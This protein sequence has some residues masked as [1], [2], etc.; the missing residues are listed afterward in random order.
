[1][2][3]PPDL[4][5]I[6]SPTEDVVVRHGAT[7]PAIGGAAYISALAARWAG[8]TAGVVAR[9]PPV[10][11]RGCS[12]SFGPNGLHREGLQPHDGSLPGFRITY[13]DDDHATY[14][15]WNMGLE[16]Q[17]SAR[18]IPEHW[19][20]GWV[21][22][23]GVGASVKMQRQ[24]LNDLPRNR[25]RGLSIGTCKAMVQ[26]SP[27][28][29]RALLAASDIFFL[30]EEEW[31]L[32][33][34]N[35][36]PAGHTGT[37]VVTRGDRGVTVFRGTSVQEFQAKPV[38]VLDPTGAGDAFCGAF[39]GAL[40]QG[41][42][43][44]ATVAIRAA[45]IV[46]GGLGASPLAEW[47]GSQITSRAGHDPDAL[48][49]IAPTV[50]ANAQRSAFDFT[51][52]PHLPA[53][54]PLALPMLWISTLHQ[55]GFWTADASSGWHAPM[56]APIDGIQRKGSDFIWAAFARAAR[57]DPSS[58]SAARMAAEPDLFAE[59]CRDD[60]G[61]CPVPDLESHC[62]LHVAHGVH[63]MNHEPHGYAPILERV[64]NSPQPI[65]SLLRVVEHQPGYLGDPMA[66]KANLLAVIL[67][68]RPERWLD[69][70]DPSS[71]Q[72]IVDYHMMRLCMRTGL[73]R[74]EDPDLE[75]RLAQRSWVDALEE[76]EIRR[77]TGRA[78]L[79]LV[80]QTGLS[81]AAI[82]GLF[83]RLGRSVCLETSEP[84]CTACPIGGECPQHADLFQPVFRT[85]AY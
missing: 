12:R 37:I 68:A 47:V 39:L 60:T 50:E 59:I 32:L 35:G 84:E 72:P 36:L 8:A 77:A 15:D 51:Q 42:A 18:D 61:V 55:Y 67:T 76:L 57:D 34:P 44:P 25:I 2:K 14:T 16:A 7:H 31:A 23:A 19:L 20:D 5:F 13:D 81:V 56:V 73:V 9:V 17:L 1:M 3:T 29:T 58:L 4:V 10:L 69:P 83:F 28:D 64:N 6:G 63:M 22:I 85:T 30:N 11:P 46:L 65:M 80:Q 38:D 24:I 71:I 78:I 40:V 21:H 66:K 82:D 49:R 45:S 27:E 48:R 79:H 74:I 75:R 52:S 26:D 70:R 54:H 62:A 41:A 53:G 33:Y 43:E